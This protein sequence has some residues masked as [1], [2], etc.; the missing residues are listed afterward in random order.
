MKRVFPTGIRRLR[1]S[2]L[3]RPPPAFARGRSGLNG[4]KRSLQSCSP[5]F[6][7]RGDD[8]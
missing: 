4:G 6:R 1:E 5:G 7:F 8:K 2:G 3:Q